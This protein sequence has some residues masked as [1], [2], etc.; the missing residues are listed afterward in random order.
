MC[1][2]WCLEFAQECKGILEEQRMFHPGDRVL[3]IGSRNVNG[4]PRPIYQTG[5]TF[6]MGID[7]EA[8]DG[9]DLVADAED[10]RFDNAWDLV[11]SMEML[12]HVQDWRRVVYNCMRA[13]KVGGALLLTT[14]SPGFEYHPY[15]ADNWRFTRLD[16]EHIFNHQ[17]THIIKRAQDPEL[18]R[19]RY[20]GV[21]VLV[22]RTRQDLIGW[23]ELLM[24]T[25][26]MNVHTDVDQ[27]WRND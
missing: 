10:L 25:N 2:K 9:V 5:S 23:Q 26:V 24:S 12:E 6:Y 11:I 20:S 8:G 1:N 18:R 16:M 19:G 15:P 27:A 3:E 21:G 13:V 22:M 17:A 14:R 7:L 4:S